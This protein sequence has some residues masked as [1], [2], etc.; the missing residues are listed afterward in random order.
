MLNPLGTSSA[1]PSPSSLPQIFLV[2]SRQLV[3]PSRSKPSYSTTASA[4][5]YSS[6]QAQNLNIQIRVYN[7][8][9]N[10]T[11]C[12]AARRRV[13]YEDDENEEE[14]EEYGNNQE[15]AMLELY[16]QSSTEEALIVHAFVDDQEVE[17]LIFKVSI[18]F[19]PSSS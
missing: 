6:F 16:S 12:G 4:S 2:F 10:S 1:P 3:V 19:F 13:R 8:S 9:R 5:S 18:F 15:I 11:L 14:G 17:V 7:L